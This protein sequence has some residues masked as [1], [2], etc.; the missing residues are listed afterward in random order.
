MA[1]AVAEALLEQP[2]DQSLS[3]GPFAESLVRH[4]LAWAQS[5]DNNRAPGRTCLDACGGLSLGKEWVRATVPGS[6][7]CGANM[8]VTP[9]GLVPMLS[10]STRAGAA[11]LQAAI[12]HGHPTGLAASELTASISILRSSRW[13]WRPDRRPAVW[14]GGRKAARPATQ[15]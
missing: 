8:R 5:P 15:A 13:A 3:A 10:S 12:T 11:Q 14:T 9:I 2:A 1:L 4:F 6:K 7:G